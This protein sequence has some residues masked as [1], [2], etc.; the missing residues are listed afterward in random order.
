MVA[1]LIF[2]TLNA[3]RK[4]NPLRSEFSESV[5]VVNTCVST[6]VFYCS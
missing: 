6:N 2:F 5:L 1:I 4:L 3:G